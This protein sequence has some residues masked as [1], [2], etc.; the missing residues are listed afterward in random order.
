MAHDPASMH[1]DHYAQNN[2]ACIHEWHFQNASGVKVQLLE[3]VSVKTVTKLFVLWMPALC[4]PLQMLS[5]WCKSFKAKG[6]CYFIFLVWIQEN[7]DQELWR[8]I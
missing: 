5:D 6:K 7:A 4:D 1:W 8:N 2:L 3:Y